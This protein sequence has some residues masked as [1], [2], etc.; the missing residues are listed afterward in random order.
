[1]IPWLGLVSRQ[2]AQLLPQAIEG[3]VWILRESI[4]IGKRSIG[5]E[6]SSQMSLDSASIIVIDVPLYRDLHIKDRLSAIS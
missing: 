4:S 6:F 5:K 3:R 2:E 1:M